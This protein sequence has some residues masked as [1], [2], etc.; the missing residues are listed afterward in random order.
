MRLTV[1]ASVVVK[2]LVEED[3]SD[4]AR[5][6]LTDC[7]EL[8]APA[9]LLAEV[10]NT[11]WKKFIREGSTT[12]VEARLKELA[13][14]P[15]IITLHDDSQLVWR[16]TQ[17]ACELQHPVYDCLYLA[18]GELADADVVT[19]DQS[20]VRKSAKASR[21]PAAIYLGDA[22]VVAGIRSVAME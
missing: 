13:S 7:F 3:L 10:A 5:L 17:L 8:H 20:L 16:A 4:E 9:L 22:A 14:V 2:W 11:I 21:D 1:D 19:A 18:C 15:E 12:S 6:L